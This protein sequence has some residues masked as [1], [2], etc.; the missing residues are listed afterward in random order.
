MVDSMKT[1]N[2]GEE[3][4]I[5]LNTNK[6]WSTN[7]AMCSLNYGDHYAQKVN[8]QLYHLQLKNIFINQYWPFRQPFPAEYPSPVN[9]SQQRH[10]YP[11]FLSTG[12]FILVQLA[13]LEHWHSPSSHHPSSI[14]STSN[15][16]AV[17]ALI[18]E[19]FLNSSA[20]IDDIRYRQCLFVKFW[21]FIKSTVEFS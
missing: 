2:D 6:P 17:A 8:P 11:G 20:A 5:W 1:W 9:P 16:T 21:R 18:S 10:R 13:C 19:L 14:V 7:G 12:D 4:A 3:N 15:D